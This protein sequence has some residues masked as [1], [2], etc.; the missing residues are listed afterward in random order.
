MK[1]RICFRLEE[2][3]AGHELIHEILKGALYDID[4]F[5]SS[6]HGHVNPTSSHIGRLV[7]NILRHV[8]TSTDDVLCQID[9]GFDYISQ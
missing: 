9:W 7:Q 5:G 6:I 8:N 2:P 3:E 4:A 1:G